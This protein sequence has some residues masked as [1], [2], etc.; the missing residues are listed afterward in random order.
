MGKYQRKVST[1]RRNA[2]TTFREARAPNFPSQGVRDRAQEEGHAGWR[3]TLPAPGGQFRT[4]RLGGWLLSVLHEDL[5]VVGMT[6]LCHQLTIAVPCFSQRPTGGQERWETSFNTK[7]VQLIG[8]ERR[9]VQLKKALF[10]PH[11]HQRR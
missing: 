11:S 7:L 4:L 3:G 5:A 9:S 1:S 2:L 8:Q 10:H 6:I